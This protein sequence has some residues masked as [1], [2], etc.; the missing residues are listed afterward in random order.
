MCFTAVI[1]MT[2]VCNNQRKNYKKLAKELNQ[3]EDTWVLLDNSNCIIQ[4]NIWLLS[5]AIQIA[6][7]QCE[8]TKKTLYIKNITNSKCY[9]I[10]YDTANKNIKIT[11][12]PETITLTTEIN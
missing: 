5:V 11:N 1:I 10:Y 7:K 3:L 4:N 8:V 2:I 9:V 6:T 12:G